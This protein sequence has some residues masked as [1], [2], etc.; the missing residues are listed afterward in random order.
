[1][2]FDDRAD[3]P[4]WIRTLGEEKKTGQLFVVA[5]IGVTT[6]SVSLHERDDRGKWKKLLTTPGFIGKNGLGKT[7]E[8]DQRTPVGEFRFT[9]AFGLADDPGCPLPYHKIT[10]EDYWSCDLREG[11]AYN[12]LVSIREYPDLDTSGSEHLADFPFHYQ[13]CLNISYN[14]EGVPGKGSA[15]FLHCFGPE[16]PYTAGCVA[17]S[18]ED[19]RT[20]LQHVR[21]DCVVVIDTLRRLSPET[22][23]EWDKTVSERNPE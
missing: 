7:K 15:I 3:S 12:H 9:R 13:Y 5:G 18:R 8:G 17:I 21:S 1:M 16:K 10:K 6:A 2:Q 20:V 11:Y 14:E 19:M 23:E 22:W 4:D